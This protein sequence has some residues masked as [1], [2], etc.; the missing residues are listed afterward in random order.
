MTKELHLET[1]ADAA[2]PQKEWGLHNG[3]VV[4]AALGL[5]ALSLLLG[6]IIDIGLFAGPSLWSDWFLSQMRFILMLAAGTVIGMLVATR[7]LQ[8]HVGPPGLQ[9]A[10]T[11][12]NRRHGALGAAP[13]RF[14]PG[15][16]PTPGCRTPADIRFSERL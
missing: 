7:M 12:G 10:G 16:C 15:E 2:E 3:L 6:W 5:V 4:L 14:A 8:A 11:V 9:N 13:I 1:G